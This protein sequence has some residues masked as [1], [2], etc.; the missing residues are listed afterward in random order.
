MSGVLRLA[1]PWSAASS[2]SNRNR[3]FRNPAACSG[4]LDLR[5]L[6]QGKLSL[7]L[8]DGFGPT[9]ASRE[10]PEI[11]RIGGEHCPVRLRERND[12]RIHGRPAAGPPP[13]AV[14]CA[15][16]AHRVPRRCRTSRGTGSSRR[17]NQHAP[18]CTRPVRRRAQLEAT[19]MRPATQRSMRPSGATA[20]PGGSRRGNP[21]RARAVIWPGDAVAAGLARRVPP[22]ARDRAPLAHLRDPRVPAHTGR[23]PPTAR[24]VAIP[25]APHAG[26]IRSPTAPVSS[27]PG[28][29]HPADTPES[30]AYA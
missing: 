25:R 21:G 23:L 14:L 26:A 27:G 11:A 19:A 29:G 17:R 7:G 28:A 18:P 24:G 8:R 9:A 15:R 6:A 20:R 13:E 22:P 16:E 1:S 4:L 2:S 12:D 3:A 30:S 10:C 5:R